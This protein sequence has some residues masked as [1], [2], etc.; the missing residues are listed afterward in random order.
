MI[1]VLVVD[2]SAVARQALTRAL[3]RSRELH[4]AGTAHDAVFARTKMERAWPDVVVLDLELPRV[5]GLAFLKQ[6]MAEHP[7]PVVV[8]SSLTVHGAEASVRALSAGAIAVFPKDQLRPGPGLLEAET[9]LARL[10]RDAAGTR[11][12]AFTPT[13]P[14]PGALPR[15]APGRG[16]SLVAI[17]ASTGGTQALEVVIAALP[18][19]CPPLAVVQHMPERF[20]AAFAERLDGLGAVRV[21]EARDGDIFRQGHVLIAPGG[22]HLSLRR[23]G[24]E[25]VAEVL[26]APP[27]NRHAP[28]V[29]VLFRAVARHLGADA[30]GFLLTGMGDDGARGLL[31]MR[32]AGATTWAQDEESCVVYGMPREAVLRGAATASLPLGRVAETIA[33]L[34]GGR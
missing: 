27:V 10:V 34:R 16:V 1:N 17:G 6:L 13:R 33:L 2:D 14:A 30:A 9:Q 31:E 7:T 20:T 11:V 4:V 22:Q 23:R 19:D 25:L 3:Q 28:S 8:C 18:A 26:S 21:R 29:D 24:A 5:D 15:A 12:R 32:Q